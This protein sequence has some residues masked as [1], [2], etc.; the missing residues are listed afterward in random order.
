MLKAIL[1]ILLLVA[2]YSFG[3]ENPH[4][5]TNDV[6]SDMIVS[7]CDDGTVTISKRNGEYTVCSTKNN[8]VEC[9]KGKL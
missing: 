6:N 7:Q 5:V 3:D 9:V 8:H 4:C 1:F 2:F